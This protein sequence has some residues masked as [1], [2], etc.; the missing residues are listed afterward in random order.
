MAIDPQIYNYVVNEE[1][2][3]DK[4]IIFREGGSSSWVY[5][6]LE[7]QVKLKKQTV[8]GQLTIDTLKEG[9]FIGESSLLHKG[10]SMRT[11]SAVAEGPVMLGTLDTARLN[12]EWERQPLRLKKLI[13][14]LM[15]HLEEA[16]DKVADLVNRS[17]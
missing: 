4:A 2:F 3:P 10:I 9:H 16:S 8:K 15:R 14:N 11:I 7:G 5:I 13:S 1:T 6:I 12:E 17:A